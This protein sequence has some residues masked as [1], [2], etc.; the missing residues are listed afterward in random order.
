[1]LREYIVSEAMTALGVP[2]TRSLAAVTTGESVFRDTV[3]AGAVLTRVAQ[4]HVRVGTFQFFAARGDTDGVRLLADY[5]IARHYPAAAGATQP[6]RALLDAVIARTASL[7]AHWQLIGFIHGVMNTD[8]MSVAGETIDYGPCAF[9]DS[10]HPGTVYS[11]IDHAGR[12]AYANQPSVAYWNLARLAETLLPLLAPESEAAIAEAHAALDAYSAAFEQAY[13][14]GLRA[15]LGLFEPH[16]G[17]ISLAHDLLAAMDAEDADFSLIFRALCDAAAA[18][19]ATPALFAD[20]KALCFW[21]QNWRTRV[22][23]EDLPG[24]ARATAMR[25]V[26]PA[27]IPRNHR[28]QAAIA[29]AQTGDFSVFEE[30]IQVLARPYDDQPDFAAYAAPPRPEEV[31]RETFCGT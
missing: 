7:I 13:H 6:Y 2:S 25:A 30:L 5:V 23:L 9:M 29:A 28:V 17:D 10:F 18:P 27:F 3:Q 22:A 11:S 15:K 26:N 24:A 31:V 16:D 14:A 8:N 20:S 1:V 19:D 12:Y 21:L 4:S